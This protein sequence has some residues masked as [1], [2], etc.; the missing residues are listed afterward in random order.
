[1]FHFSKFKDYKYYDILDRIIFSIN[2][3]KHVVTGF[4]PMHVHR[5]RDIPSTMSIDDQITPVNDGLLHYIDHKE[6]A[7]Y[8]KYSNEVYKLRTKTVKDRI[9]M[10]AEKRQKKQALKS[11]HVQVFTYM[12]IKDKIQPIFLKKIDKDGNS[13]ELKNP[14]IIGKKI[15]PVMN[16]STHTKYVDTYA[17]LLYPLVQKGQ[18]KKNKVYD[19]IFVIYSVT[20]IQDRISKIKYKLR[21]LDEKQKILWF[22]SN[23]LSR[24]SDGWTDQFYDTM[25]LDDIKITNMNV[26]VRPD[27]KFINLTKELYVDQCV[28]ASSSNLDDE[29]INQNNNTFINN[30]NVYINNNKLSER[31][32]KRAL[33]YG[34][35][36]GSLH[37]YNIILQKN[38]RGKYILNTPPQNIKVQIFKKLSNYETDYLGRENKANYVVYETDNSSKNYKVELDVSTYVFDDI[39]RIGGWH[40]DNPNYVK[41]NY[42]NRN[43]QTHKIMLLKK[44]W[45]VGLLQMV[46]LNIK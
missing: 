20:H 41:V 13:I 44:Y 34:P 5:G 15:D 37:L 1:M 19:E 30:N 2:N 33:E 22:D 45:I 9:K 43:D 7:D 31:D 36:Y 38:V 4:T 8:D 14:I 29:S 26:P 16:A 11:K 3:T 27:Y 18:L 12:R 40:F 25:F 21:T 10:S 28:G 17:R 35:R 32:V 6:M 23:N 42:T 46:S 24:D 39:I